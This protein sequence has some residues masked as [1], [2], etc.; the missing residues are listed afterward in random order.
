MKEM[1]DSNVSC[2]S[3]RK[4]MRKLNKRKLNKRKLNKKEKIKQKL[5]VILFV[6]LF[7]HAPF[8]SHEGPTAGD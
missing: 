1:K 4:L 6:F 2:N 8:Q 7:T 5:I 3:L